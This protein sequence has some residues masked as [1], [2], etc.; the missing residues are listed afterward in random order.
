MTMAKATKATVETS[1]NARIDELKKELFTLRFKA[2]LGQ[3]EQPHKVKAIKKE[4]ARILTAENAKK[5]G[6]AK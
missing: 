1:A 6:G 5:Q 4:I 3:I 2:A